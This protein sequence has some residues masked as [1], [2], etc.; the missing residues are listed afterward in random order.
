MKTLRIILGAALIAF[1]TIGHAQTTTNNATSNQNSTSQ[2]GAMNAGVNAGVTL[3][4]SSSDRMKT[5]P[6]MG[7]NSYYG[8]FSSDNCFNSVGASA[9]W[10]GFGASAVAPVEGTSCVAL[11]AYERLQQG[12]QVETDPLVQRAVR[13]AAYDT[14]CQSSGIVKKAMTKNGLCSDEFADKDTG[15]ATA[16]DGT[17]PRQTVASLS[18]IRPSAAR[19]DIESFY[20]NSGN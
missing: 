13:Q 7:G 4:S 14:L 16:S 5:V 15:T 9:A 20:S 17:K 6:S 10:M 1:T 2:S 8:S 3:N 12:A 18:D 19:Q 11:R